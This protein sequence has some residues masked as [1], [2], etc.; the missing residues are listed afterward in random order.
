MKKILF[1]GATGFL[2]KNI[3]SLLEKNYLV[4]TL[5]IED[6]NT[7]KVNLVKGSFE[8]KEFYDIVLHAAGKAH[9]VPKTELEKQT[10]FDINYHGTINLCTA[11]EK[12]IPK[13]FVFISTVA[14]YGMEFGE[15]IS[16]EYDL[17]GTTPYA[18]SKIM[19]EEYLIKW[20]KAHN[21]NLTILR[22]ALLAGFTPPGNLG[23]MISGLKRNRYLSVAGSK[24]KKSIA[25]ATDIARLIPI[26]EEK[27]GIFNLCDNHHPSFGELES[28]ICLQLNIK[29]PLNVP[30]F[31]AILLAKVGDFF[32][33]KVPINTSKLMKITKNLTFSNQKIK[34]ELQFE[35][36]DV[37]SNFKIQ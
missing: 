35:P 33:A 25:M 13:A 17:L 7:Y 10:F 34:E 36:T 31:V 8:L 29:K 9:I 24:A 2:G 5:G 20:A 28:L 26:V 1:T 16:E 32:G 23:A 3:L 21:V 14:V 6:N 15:D 11:L 12:N 30:L 18:K 4:H 22:P 37:L 27:S 19:A